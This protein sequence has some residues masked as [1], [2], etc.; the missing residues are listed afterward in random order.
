M[1]SKFCRN[2]LILGICLCVMV[3]RSLADELENVF[4]Q[5]PAQARPWVYWF[6]MGSTITR[7]GITGDLQALHD[8]GF[9][10]SVMCSMADICT[11]W[12]APIANSPTPDILTFNDKWWQLVRHATLESRRLGLEFGIGNC[13]GYE[14]CG[15]PWIT[16]ELS[17][18][19]VVWSETK[20]SGP[21]K[22]SGKVLK[23]SPDSHAHQPFPVYIGNTGKLDLPEVPAR[24]TLFQDIALVA[25]PAK[26][27]IATNQIFDLSNK[28]S[29]DGK[30][31]WDAP[32]GDWVIYRFGHTTMG[33]MLQPCQ[34]EAIGLQVDM[35]S[36]EAMAFNMDYLI[37]TIQKHAGDLI[38]QG[39]NFVWF[40]SYEAGTPTWTPKM[41]EEF[42]ARRGYDL[43]RFLP[44]F[45]QRTVGSKN[46]TKQFNDDFKRTVKDLY[47]DVYFTVIREKLHAAKLQFCNEPYTG[48]FETSEVITNLNMA[49]SEFWVRDGKYNPSATPK[50]VSAAQERGINRISA[51][52]FTA[53]PKESQW[54]ETPAGLKVVG[55]AAFCD[56]VNRFVLHRYVHQPYGEQYRPGFAMGQWGTHFDRTQTWWHEFK[57]TVK[58]WQRCSALL[59]WGRIAKNDFAVSSADQGL[60]LKSI[61]RSDGMAEVYFVAN[62]APTKGAADC[63][64][65]VT[66]KQP[67]LWNPNTG[68]TRDLPEFQMTDDKTR[69][70]LQ[71]AATESCFI[72]FR[73]PLSRAEKTAGEKNFHD[74]Q[75]VSEI[76][77]A[78]MVQFAPKWGGPGNPVEFASL[79]NWTNRAEIGIKYFSGTAVYEKTFDLPPA[80][81]GNHHPKIF[82]DLGTVHDVASVTLNGKDFGVVWTSPWRVDISSVV[83]AK[84]NQLKIK[85][86]NCWANRQ[87]GDQQLPPDCEYRKGD[88]GFGG[89]L[90]SFPDWLVKNQSRPSGRFTF[91]TWNYFSSES[92]LKSSGLLGPVKLVEPSN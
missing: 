70:P 37:G 88:R 82:L 6:W 73:K 47:R 18:Q 54:D 92:P 65:G 10:G 77:G 66:G 58:Y 86:T 63:A 68:E 4:R 72:I 38:G 71:F 7:D 55:D 21:G 27:N 75:T 50:V 32:A 42:Q 57:A 8:A 9:G 46:E 23:P 35:M 43:V 36:R 53:A 3:S 1:K 49:V 13:A 14:T 26:G 24:K 64:F 29:A 81:A 11:P 15:G 44:T 39:L 48:P 69:V 56:G 40:D 89:P 25:V 52:A 51:E 79:E 33:S 28:L 84:H 5:P 76:T 16:P 2:F 74:F 91:T 60:L 61:H 85:I 83:K 19:E 20:F 30:L 45:A 59:Q 41:R 87:I 62:L 80:T 12:P 31:D 17:M 90:K 78:W 67:E 22:F 34:W